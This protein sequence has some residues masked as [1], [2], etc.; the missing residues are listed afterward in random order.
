MKKLLFTFL[1]LL[2]F[3]SCGEQKNHH[4][5]ENSF[6]IANW[7][8][9]TFFDAVTD[10][11]E[12]SEFT[13]DNWTE[14]KY[15]TRL[16]RLTDVIFTINAD[17]FVFEEIENREVLQDLSNYLYSKNSSMN[18]WKFYCF[19]KEQNSS[20]GCAVISRFPLENFCV[21]SLKIQ[22]QNTKQPSSRPILQVTANINEKKLMIFVNHWKSKSGGSEKSDIWRDWQ[23]TILGFVATKNQNEFD[24]NGVIFIGDFNRDLSEF[25]NEN[26]QS[27][28]RIA[29]FGEQKN[30][31]MYSVWDFIQNEEIGSYYYKGQWSKI[32][33]MF[34]NENL[35]IIDFFPFINE[36]WTNEQDIPQK[37]SIYNGQGYS[38][39]L[40][41]FCALEFY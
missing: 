40:P 41:I 33:N 31:S 25:Y 27:I 19:A 18:K 24:S 35:R 1:G 6:T 4:Y 3:I 34:L 30:L 15:K 10:G 8:V 7:N 23:E 38:D 37:Y 39:H 21:H 22:T 20:I 11:N 12:Y 29:N 9:Q 36:M 5:Y 14:E 16:Q 2:F 13:K 17:I 32:D 26:E 28:I